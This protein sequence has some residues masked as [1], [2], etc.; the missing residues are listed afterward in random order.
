MR[1]AQRLWRGWNGYRIIYVCRWGLNDS[2]Q[3]RES[4]EMLGWVRGRIQG[5]DGGVVSVG[6]AVMRQ[7]AG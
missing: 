2:R 4:A 1:R 7:W 5:G 3:K 6:A